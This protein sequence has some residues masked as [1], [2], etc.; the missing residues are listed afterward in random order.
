MYLK[1]KY[2]ESGE[3]ASPDSFS[4]DGKRNE[5]TETMGREMDGRK[6]SSRY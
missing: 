4:K 6:R 1:I 5:E 2:R 3:A